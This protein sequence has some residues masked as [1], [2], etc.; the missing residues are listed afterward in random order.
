M[1]LFVPPA[2]SVTP[3]SFVS[4][5]KS[6]DDCEELVINTTATINNLSFYQVKNSVIQDRKLHIAECEARSWVWVDACSF[7]VLILL[8]KPRTA[9][10]HIF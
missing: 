10:I 7:K 1:A 6:I 8:T 2:E 4:E 3:L 9:G 5:Y